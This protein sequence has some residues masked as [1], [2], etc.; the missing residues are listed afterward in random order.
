MAKTKTANGSGSIRKRK[1]GTWEARFCAGTDP[2]TG[3]IIR[4]SVYG[5]T[6]KEVREKLTALTAEID[7]GGYFEPSK[8]TLGQ[9]IT[10]YENDFMNGIKYLTKKSYIAQLETHVRPALGATK[11]SKLT[12]VMINTFYNNLLKEG[13]TVPKYDDK[14]KPIKDKNG[15]PLTERIPLS[16]KSVR[17]VHGILTKCLKTAIMM[18]YLKENPALPVADNLPRAEKKEVRPL[19]DEEV[20]RFMK[21]LDGE[22]YKRLFQAILFMGLRESEAAGLSWNC[23]DFE[24]G[25]VTIKQQLIKRPKADGG[26]S[27][28]STK[29]DKERVLAPAPFV[30]DI[31]KQRKAEQVQQRFNAGEAREGFQ[32]EKEQRTALC[33]TT[34]TGTR[35]CPQTIYNHYKKIAGKIGAP[36]TNVHTL[37]HTFATVSLQGGDNPKMVQENLG[38]YSV[39]FTMRTYGHVS[40]RMAQESA[41]RMQKYI[42]AMG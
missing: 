3:K 40:Q 5:K 35:L 37:R 22:E 38:H 27:L 32:T 42:E 13:Q 20:K 6:Q 11:L 26:Y 1:D 15:V 7:K 23:I 25:T 10:I 14:G 17:N 31:L 21:E 34:A 18:K 4:K 8:I 30:L 16:A 19:T 41:E 2:G 29:S 12:P 24:N 36:E 33:F 9:W 28:A 39:E